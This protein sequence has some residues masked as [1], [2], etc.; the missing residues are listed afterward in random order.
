MRKEVS[1]VPKVL[2]DIKGVPFLKI[3][4][5]YLEQQGFK[6]I[7]LGIGYKGEMIVDFCK[8]NFSH[9]DIHFSKE[10]TP[11]GTGGALKFARPF[12]KSEPFF[13]LNGDCFCR[14]DYPSLFRF[15]QEKSAQATLA[16]YRLPE[17]KDFGSITLD[18]NNQILNFSEKSVDQATQFAS[19][20]IYCFN[21]SVF[22]LM[23][24]A[25]A[26][27]IETDFFPTL[28]GKDFYGFETK[29][30][31]IDIG[32]PDRYKIAQNFLDKE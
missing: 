32:T 16:V 26:F 4:L 31:F 22:D 29:E 12:I 5:R 21:Q 27:S 25:E 7:V 10:E 23:P 30:E 19:V 3:L 11:L 24:Q 17:K 28:V 2:A 8:N 6:Q 20:G 14:F 1:D 15:H 18:E 13:A 9:L